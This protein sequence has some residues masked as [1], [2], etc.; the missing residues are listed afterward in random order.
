MSEFHPIFVVVP[1]SEHSRN[2]VFLFPRLLSNFFFNLIVVLSALFLG[3][4][5]HRLNEFI[6]QILFQFF[7]VKF[8]VLVNIYA[9]EFLSQCIFEISLHTLL[10]DLVR[11]VNPHINFVHS[12]KVGVS[13]HGSSVILRR[14]PYCRRTIAIISLR[15]DQPRNIVALDAK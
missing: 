3:L 6:N 7:L 2:P 11:W 14:R 8:S 13:W 15:W 4:V 10:L 1:H 9:A 5:T 12:S